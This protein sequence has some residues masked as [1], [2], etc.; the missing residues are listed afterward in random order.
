MPNRWSFILLEE[1]PIQILIWTC[2]ELKFPTS[3]KVGRKRLFIP[4]ELSI[5]VA[6]AGIYFLTVN[7][8]GQTSFIKIVSNG[9]GSRNF[10]NDTTNTIP[11]RCPTGWHVPSSAE[12]SQ[13][14]EYVG[15]QSSYSCGGNSVNVAKALA[16]TTGWNGSGNSCAIGNNPGSNNLTGFSALPA[17]NSWAQ[18]YNNFGDSALFWSTS[19]H[20]IIYAYY[21]T[22][23]SSQASTFQF[24]MMR[25]NGLSVR[26]L[27]DE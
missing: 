8:N 9:N 24:F 23:A 13:L 18:G 4:T 20:E 1:K 10:G 19:D 6:N 3:R 14:V 21:R 5:N 15:S 27:L 11:C 25:S 7:Q 2:R 12:W 16:S 22:L 26:C 17:G